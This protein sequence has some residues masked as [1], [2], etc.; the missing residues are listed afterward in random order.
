MCDRKLTREIAV[1]IP[2]LLAGMF[3]GQIPPTTMLAQMTQGGLAPTL[4]SASAASY[5]YVSKPGELT[6]QVNIWG[7]VKNPGRY[8]VGGTTDLLQ[9]VSYAGGPTADAKLDEVRI[10]R[11]VRYESGMHVLQY[12]VNLDDIPSVDSAKLALYPGDTIFLDHTGWSTFRDVLTVVTTAAIIT[13]AVANVII[14][15]HRSAY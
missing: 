6:M 9:L 11:F 14:A 2:L 13:G 12:T 5:Y 7:S 10:T 1:A 4:P 3:L 8:E 15:S